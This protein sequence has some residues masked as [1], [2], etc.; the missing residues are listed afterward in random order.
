MFFQSSSSLAAAPWT[1]VSYFGRREGGR[2]RR[3]SKCER[4]VVAEVG[5]E[6]DALLVVA[7][8]LEIRGGEGG[9]KRGVSCERGWESG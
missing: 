1:R 4:K 3:V 7:S 9:R 5:L 2:E 6:V 8:I